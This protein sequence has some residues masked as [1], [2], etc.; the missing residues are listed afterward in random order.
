M[1]SIPKLIRSTFRDLLRLL[2]PMRG[3]KDAYKFAFIVH[4]RDERDMIR[5]FPFL[6]SSPG[7]IKKFIQRYFWPVT[8]SE[9]T[10]L[11]SNEGT[12]VEGFI[13]S[14]PMTAY[15]MMKDRK[16]AKRQIRKAVK[17]ARNRGAKIAGLGAL[18]SSLS[19]GGLD[20]L[21]IKGTA[22][23]T[24]H[25]YTGYN[26]TKTLLSK[27]GG[28]NLSTSTI[29]VVGAAGSIGSISAE[30]LADSGARNLLL[31]DL[32]RKKELVLELKDRLEKQYSGI[33]IDCST[34]MDLLKDAVG[35]ITAT[36]TP[37][38]LLKNHHISTGTIIVD[39]AQP[40]DISEELYE[41]DDILILEA[42]AVHTPGI[43]SNFN[44]GLANPNDNFCCLA[45]VLI[46]ASNKHTHNFV[47]NR[48]KMEDIEHIRK[49]GEAL[50]FEVSQ[51]Q[52]ERG[53]L[54]KQ[55][56]DSVLKL[57]HTRL[58]S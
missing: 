28:V 11:K 53:L 21:D 22:I 16:G 26:V 18:T 1:G 14:I 35:I 51:P 15:E 44:M 30:I 8:V 43:S 45:E 56:I 50:G 40:S 38:A 25:A 24:G 9:I 32:D 29:G 23:T 13:I 5:R 47:I 41:R 37:E 54:S 7:F 4:P 33:N 10:G 36:N 48:A 19:R 39:D 2:I 31:I 42:G 17:L 3:Y 34:D 55:K 12:S 20:L 27:L 57:L 49:G 46:L 52:N 6:E 58:S